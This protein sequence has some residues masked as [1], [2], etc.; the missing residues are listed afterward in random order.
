MAAMIKMIAT[1][2][3]QLDQRESSLPFFHGPISNT[4]SE[5]IMLSQGV[6]LRMCI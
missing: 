5:D 3:K 1:T 2:T 6:M 4:L